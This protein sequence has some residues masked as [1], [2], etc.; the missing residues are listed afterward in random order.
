MPCQQFHSSV[1][2][3]KRQPRFKNLKA[4][5]LGLTKKEALAKFQKETFPTYT[6]QEME[7]LRKKYTP[8]QIEAI[9]TGE[10]TIN[11]E[12]L[13]IQGRF[14]D[15]AYRPT[16]VEDYTHMD[17]RY[18]LKPDYEG[19]PQEVKWLGTNEW[20][21]K[22]GERISKIT[23]RNTNNQ[24]TRAMARA[25][26]KVKESQGQDV[27]DLT[28]EELAD[29][30]RNPELLSKYLVEEDVAAA[31]STATDSNVL[32]RAQVLQVDE[33]IDSAWEQE[34]EK[35][36]AMSDPSEV[37]PSNVE[38]WEDGP[39]GVN[40]MHSAEAVELGKVP[41][42]EGLY[43]AAADP[44]D[45]GRDDSGAFQEIKRL[46]GLK[47]KEVQSILAKILV[48]RQV[49]NQTRLGKIRSV[50]VIAIAGNGNGRL[51]LGHAKSTEPQ[52][53]SGTAQM[54]AIRNMKPIPRY[55]NRTIFGNVTGKV[56]ATIVELFARPPGKFASS[57]YIDT[58]NCFPQQK[59]QLTNDRRLWYPMPLAN[60]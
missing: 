17:P 36:S 54:L 15:D 51:G 8:D 18:D 34:L 5:E 55:E 20:M 9:K 7:Q 32:T 59:T 19:T 40:R 38:L 29:L 28:S 57:I 4:E 47:L 13:V 43:K 24:L 23:D 10:Q 2:R 1:A 30:E 27:I 25:L 44:E 56:S 35:L 45:E 3:P 58:Q 37:G 42:V 53:A 48:V 21:D 31:D 41:G 26:R 49:H 6:E 46:T 22:F 60:L 11:P 52:I 14:R 39:A 12:D 50:S 16:Y 33:A